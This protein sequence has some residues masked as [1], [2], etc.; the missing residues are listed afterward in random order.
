MCILIHL[1]VLHHLTERRLFLEYLLYT[2]KDFVYFPT[3]FHA[4]NTERR[5]IQTEICWI[6][7][8][9]TQPRESSSRPYS[10]AQL[11][12]RN[13]DDLFVQ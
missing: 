6:V 10:D 4:Y 8:F 12:L 1:F 7:S 3:A 11:Y 13:D 5:S 9:K 2:W